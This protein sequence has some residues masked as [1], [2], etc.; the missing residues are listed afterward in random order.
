MKEMQLSTRTKCMHFEWFLW[1]WH[2]SVKKQQKRNKIFANFSDQIWMQMCRTHPRSRLELIEQVHWTICW[3]TNHWCYWCHEEE[4]ELGRY[5]DITQVI[6]YLMPKVI[7]HVGVQNMTARDMFLLSE[8]FFTSLGLPPMPKSFWE[9][10]VLVKPTN[11]E[12]ICHAS[13][14]D[15]C[16]TSDVR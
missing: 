8:E 16:G 10:S 7:T 4:G 5:S 13:A 6:D 11:R 2:T 14:W 12:I 15:F 3:K 9:K 1:H